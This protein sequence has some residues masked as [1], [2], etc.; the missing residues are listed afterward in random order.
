MWI[1]GGFNPVSVD[2]NQRAFSRHSCEFQ[3]II[4]RNNSMMSV[5]GWILP[6]PP[7]LTP[8]Q[9]KLAAGIRG[10]VMGNEF[11]PGMVRVWIT[12]TLL[13]P[14]NCLSGGIIFSPKHSPHLK[15]SKS[16]RCLEV[17]SYFTTRFPVGLEIYVRTS[18]R[19]HTGP[20]FI[21]QGMSFH[22]V[23]AKCV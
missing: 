12:Q 5:L 17:S 7:F 1:F 18:V 16:P 20:Y 14:L 10:L 22:L 3:G 4:Y 19:Q 21:R 8:V 13:L 11:S 23:L 15:D 9:D 6:N 2:I